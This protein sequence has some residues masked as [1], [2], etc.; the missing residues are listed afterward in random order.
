METISIEQI[1]WKQMGVFT[2]SGVYNELLI[3]YIL[4]TLGFTVLYYLSKIL[5]PT[6][7]KAVF[8]P[9]NCYFTLSD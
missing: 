1:D 2:E 8:G 7:V 6:F 9:D 4:S 3:T 5:Y